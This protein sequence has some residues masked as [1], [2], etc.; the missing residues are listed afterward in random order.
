[1]EL[2]ASIWGSSYWFFIHTMTFTYPEHPTTT[3][4]KK[5]YDMLQNLY[6]V[7]PNTQMSIYYQSL[8]IEYPIKPYLDSKHDL[9]KWGWYIHNHINTKLNKPKV[10]KGHLNKQRCIRYSIYQSKTP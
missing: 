8:L 9:I 5:Y 4:K 10:N 2:D 3:I 1:M 6:L 7:I